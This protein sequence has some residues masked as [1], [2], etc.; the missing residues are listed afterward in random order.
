MAPVGPEQSLTYWLTVQEMRNKKPL[1]PPFESSGQETY[2]NG[3]KFQFNISP[4]QPGALYLLN[5]GP[6][7][8]GATEYD[9]LFPT[10]ANNRGVAQVGGNQLVQTSWNYFVEHEGLEKLWIIWSPQS[11]P[12]LDAIFK[13]AAGH[14]GVIDAAQVSKLQTYL[15]NYESAPSEAKADKAQNRTFIKGHSDVL[16][17][18]I[19]LSHR[20]F[21]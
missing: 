7:P 13:D 21:E 15:N 14:Q 8:T 2:G 4:T 6:G 12:D 5:E 3:W 9:V 18:L 20:A 11:L 16:I 1:G 17:K 19:E 10:P